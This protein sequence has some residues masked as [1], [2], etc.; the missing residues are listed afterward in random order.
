MNKIGFK[1]SEN[2]EKDKVKTDT[3]ETYTHIIKLFGIIPLFYSK[4]RHIVDS[5]Q[6]GKI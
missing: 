1:S 5:Q 3:V 6:I 4:K 2:N